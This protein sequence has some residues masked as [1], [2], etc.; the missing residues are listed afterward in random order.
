MSGKNKIFLSFKGMKVAKWQVDG[1]EYVCNR[2]NTGLGTPAFWLPPHITTCNFLPGSM[3]TVKNGIQ[4]FGTQSGEMKN[5]FLKNLVL[6]QNLKVSRD[7]RVIV[8]NTKITNT[9][10]A[11]TGGQD[12]QFGFRYNNLP[13]NISSIVFSKNGES[14]NFKR[15]FVHRIF[16]HSGSALIADVAKK[17]KIKSNYTEITGNSA[18]LIG[19]GMCIKVTAAPEKLFEGSVIGDYATLPTVTYEP[20]FKEITLKSGET[21][22]FSQIFQ[23]GD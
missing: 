12:V 23:I 1:K 20:L 21:V 4:V 5:P 2:Y 14:V 11:E 18:T 6:K 10:D 22:S 8:F 9:A 17:F 19:K 3:R 7:C 13:D 16:A 15:Q